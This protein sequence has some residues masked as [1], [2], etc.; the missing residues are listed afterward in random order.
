MKL[1]SS[2]G[3]N[4]V[5]E[6]SAVSPCRE[7]SCLFIHHQQHNN[8]RHTSLL[9]MGYKKKVC[10]RTLVKYNIDQTSSPTTTSPS[11]RTTHTRVTHTFPPFL[12]IQNQL[13]RQWKWPLTLSRSLSQSFWRL[14]RCAITVQSSSVSSFSS[15]FLLSLLSCRGRTRSGLAHKSSKTV[16]RVALESWEAA[17]KNG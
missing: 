6:T 11:T 1:H 7:R 16:V 2:Q 4:I 15:C 9:H 8:N 12:A 17:C 5:F 10:K 13:Y 14:R 3:S